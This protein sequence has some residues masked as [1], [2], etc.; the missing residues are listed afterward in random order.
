MRRGKYFRKK[1]K[2]THFSS[3]PNETPGFPGCVN[4]N[5]S[6]CDS[7]GTA[8]S[9]AAFLSSQIPRPTGTRSRTTKRKQSAHSTVLDRNHITV[10]KFSSNPLSGNT[11][12][13]DL[14]TV[15]LFSFFQQPTASDIA[16]LR[17]KSFNQE[18]NSFQD[19]T[20]KSSSLFT[21][22]N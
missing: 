12:E 6:R 19:G 21:L 7:A 8:S 3:E 11:Y 15:F 10:K 14:P 4:V 1:S 17:N 2:T 13:Q 5:C 22:Q 9:T 16:V 18:N 20:I